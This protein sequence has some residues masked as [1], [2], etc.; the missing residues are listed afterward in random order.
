MDHV[1]GNVVQEK[2]QDVTTKSAEVKALSHIAMLSPNPERLAD[3][4]SEMLG[5]ERT[6]TTNDGRIYMRCNKIHHSLV[7][8]PG[9]KVGLEHIAFTVESEEKLAEAKGKVE[10]F[11]Y[12]VI[13]SP[14]EP[15]QGKGIRFT[16]PQNI[17]IELVNG[18]ELVNEP[19]KRS[20]RPKKLGHI[21]FA[22]QNPK[23]FVKFWT[24][25]L[26]FKVSDQVQEQMFWM[27]CNEDHH[28]VAVIKSDWPTGIHHYAW[29]LSDFTEFRLLCDQQLELGKTMEYGPG[30]HGP[31]NNLFTYH[32][33]ADGNRIELFSDLVQVWEDHKPKIWEM[34]P[35]TVNQWGP[36]PPE[37]W[38]V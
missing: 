22:S 9:E 10:A 11:G 24:E 12:K 16:G 37:S 33:D 25:V 7:I 15:G 36:A 6:T 32:F 31:G 23:E 30:R 13:D 28:T 18:M 21:N 19:I 27:Y 8:I 38:L 4:Y 2:R 3:Y 20:L 34:K 35:T 26:G 1:I 14:F 17:V 5:M 29:E